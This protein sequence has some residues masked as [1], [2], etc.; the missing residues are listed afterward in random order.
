MLKWLMGAAGGILSGGL[1]SKRGYGDGFPKG[2]NA[3]TIRPLQCGWVDS[4]AAREE[5]IRTH[6][7]PFL[8]QQYESIKGSGRGKVVLLYKFFEEITKN[9]LVPHYQ[10]IGDCVAHAFGLGVDVLTAVQILMLNRPEMWVTKCATEIIYA[11]SR[12]E[13]GAGRLRRSDGSTGVWASEFVREWG[14]LLRQAYEN[15]KYDY[16]NYSGAVARKLG[17]TGVPNILEPLCR[18]HP[19]KTCAI[20][21]SWEEC[22]DAV[23]NGYPVAMCSNAGFNTKRDKDGFLR[24]SRRPWY[25]AM[26]ILGIDDKSRRRGALVQ[27]SWGSDW[28]SGPTRHD[29]P[30]GSFW[31]DAS[32][33]NYALRQGDSIALSGYVGYPRVNI[34][35]YQI[36]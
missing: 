3:K 29:Q 31:A 15:G 35:D 34:P 9:P 22:R 32:A 17:K 21:R 28:V 18:L 24:R 11:G 5:F 25:H 33:I 2:L 36:W 27:N 16:T 4:S 6:P 14:I 20:V 12:V 13:V 8:S 10:E 23:A 26:V 30:A 7:E 1:F 19:V